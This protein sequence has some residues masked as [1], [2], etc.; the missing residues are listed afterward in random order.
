MKHPFTKFGN[1]KKQSNTPAAVKTGK[2]LSFGQSIFLL[3][4]AGLALLAVSG[5]YWYQ[6]VF[7]DPDRVMSDVLDKSLQTTSV[8]RTVEQKGTQNQV[9]QSLYLAF[10]PDVA[11]RS[12][13]RLQESGANGNSSVVTETIG[14]K[15]TDYVRYDSI[16]ISSR[17]TPKQ[18]FDNIVNVWGKRQQS[19]DSQQPVSFLND[20]LFVAVPFGNLDKDQR[21]VIKDEISKVNLYKTSKTETQYINSR[22]TMTYTVDISPKALVQ[23]LAKYVLVT[24]VGNAG[25]LDPEQYEGA[26]ATQITIQVDLLS[27]HVNK[28]EFGESGRTETYGGYNIEQFVKLPAETIEI[29]ELQNRLSEIEKKMQQSATQQ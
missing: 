5:R 12:V 19:P 11:A 27:R 16:D 28:I 23:V 26:P 2:G 24:G 22:P 4:V 25:E 1:R 8:Y 7:T 6:N 10:S 3:V 13:T 18:S 9:G 15:N 14:T 21:R 29:D 20:A 17:N